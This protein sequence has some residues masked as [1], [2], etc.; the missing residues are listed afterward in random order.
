MKV[1][2]GIESGYQDIFAHLKLK[3]MLCDSVVIRRK[4]VYPVQYLHYDTVSDAY[5]FGRDLRGACGF[6]PQRA[7]AFIEHHGYQA[8]HEA[9]SMSGEVLSLND[10]QAL[11]L[12]NDAI[13]HC[14]RHQHQDHIRK[15]ATTLIE[16]FEGAGFPAPSMKHLMMGFQMHTE[17][18]ICQAQH[19]YSKLLQWHD[20]MIVDTQRESSQLT[21]SQKQQ[22][23]IASRTKLTQSVAEIFSLLAEDWSIQSMLADQ[24]CK[25][26]LE[27]CSPQLHQVSASSVAVVAVETESS[28][29]TEECVICL[30]AEPEHIYKPCMH[31]VACSSCAFE[32]RARSANCPW[33]RC[34]L[35]EL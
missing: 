1:R 3:T 33:C 8:T 12:A 21:I 10:P 22:L 31:R 16:R 7:Q 35:D 23:R 20:S 6:S 25:D 2:S 24:A 9:V 4:G 19:R 13:L 28:G 27:L 29:V 11:A 18:T 26:L 34:V 15:V 32:L 14:W 17:P 5:L 30:D